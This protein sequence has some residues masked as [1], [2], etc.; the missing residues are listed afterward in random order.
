MYIHKSPKRDADTAKKKIA[1]Y[2]ITSGIDVY[3]VG[4]TLVTFT[5][6]DMEMNR[7]KITDRDPISVVIASLNSVSET[8][9]TCYVFYPKYI[10]FSWIPLGSWIWRR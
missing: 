7:N 9:P 6:K 1:D 4:E 10:G 2:F 8:A 3:F 5:E